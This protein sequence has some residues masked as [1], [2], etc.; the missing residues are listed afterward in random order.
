VIFL[1]EGVLM[2]STKQYLEVNNNTA[3]RLHRTILPI[4]KIKNRVFKVLF[5]RV[6]GAH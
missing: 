6:L 3:S 2:K 4:E 5:L 1:D